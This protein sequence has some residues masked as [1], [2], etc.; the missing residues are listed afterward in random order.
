MPRSTREGPSVVTVSDTE[1][2]LAGEDRERVF[3]DG[4][5]ASIFVDR[6]ARA[7]GSDRKNPSPAYVWHLN[8][9]QRA[10][11]SAAWPALDRPSTPPSPV[12]SSTPRTSRC[13]STAPPGTCVPSASTTTD[14]PARRQC[15]QPSRRA[16][17]TLPAHCPS[18][19]AR[20]AYELEPDV[21]DLIQYARPGHR[22]AHP[23]RSAEGELGAE[24]R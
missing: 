14:R 20:T 23:F 18:T 15:S 2:D 19:E 3:G 6:F 13:S 12:R 16:D 9:A 17:T 7:V 5:D 21:H 10:A 1:N 24:P 22:S 8:N 11:S 4:S